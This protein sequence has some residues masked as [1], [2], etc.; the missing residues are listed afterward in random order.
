MNFVLI[1]LTISCYGSVTNEAYITKEL[2]HKQRT[3]KY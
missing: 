3:V 2:E 1:K